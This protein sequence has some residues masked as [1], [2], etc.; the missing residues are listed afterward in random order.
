MKVLTAT[1][2]KAQSMKAHLLEEIDPYLQAREMFGDFIAWLRSP[3]C[4]ESHSDLEREVDKRGMDLMRALYQGR[5]DQLSVEETAGLVMHQRE[6]DEVFRSRGRDIEVKFGRVRLNRLGHKKKGKPADFPQDRKLN[7]P[8]E[9]YSLG[10]RERM[11]E[12]ASR[13]SWDG[14]VQAVDS[15]TGAHVPKRQAQQ[16]AVR[17]AQD[18]DA[19]YETRQQAVNDILSANALE[20]A[21]SDSTGITMLERG[22]REQTRKAGA[23]AKERRVKGDPMAPKKLRRHDKR[24]A[25]VTANWE[26]EQHLRTADEVMAGLDRSPAEKPRRTPKPV[27]KRVRASV[28]KSQAEGIS[29]MFDE[30]QRRNPD[31]QRTNVVLVDGEENQLD[32]IIKQADKRDISMHIV[33]DLIHVIHYLWIACY[34]LC[35]KQEQQTE[36][37]VRHFIGMLLNCPARYVAA[38]IR[39]HATVLQLS[40]ELREPIDRCC[41]YLL[42]YQDFLRYDEYIAQGF[43]ISTG[44]IE[45][46]CRYLVQDRMDITGARWD[47]PGAEALLR[48]R[49]IR[50]SGDW[51]AYWKFHERE[52]F[53][54]NHVDR[55]A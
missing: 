22:L 2:Q 29:E 5:L 34:V 47:V 45:G 46:T 28:Q 27:D 1:P 51:D 25:I 38:S 14:A 24:M 52:E 17:A 11:S 18:F 39:R 3:R 9:L 32:A 10:V 15:N 31:G 23:K 21:S 8:K 6:A 35:S 53:S 54:R 37:L 7:L 20:I 36:H 41:N 19:F 13:G 12:E 33:M 48:L 40:A 26:A 44:V 42:K 43:P 55:A 30:M 16:L 4:P 50:C 49:A